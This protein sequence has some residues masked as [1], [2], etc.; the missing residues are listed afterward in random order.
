MNKVIIMVKDKAEKESKQLSS[1]WKW[2]CKTVS[3]NEF[4][5]RH[6]QRI[7]MI[8]E[9]ILHYGKVLL[10]KRNAILNSHSI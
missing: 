7:S 8:I 1:D 10:L 4:H 9:N 5:L 2:L 3:E 6:A